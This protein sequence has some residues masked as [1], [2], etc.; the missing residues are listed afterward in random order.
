MVPRVSSRYGGVEVSR[1]YEMGISMRAVP[2]DVVDTLIDAVRDL[3]SWEDWDTNEDPPGLSQLSTYGQGNLSGGRSEEDFAN[4]V[5]D[6][7]W[8]AAGKHIKV[9]VTATYMENL[10]HEHYDYE[11]EEDYD[12]WLKKHSQ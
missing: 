1:Y 12:K 10:P 2:K 5:R 3:W 9:V 11:E 7:I 6:A 8:T 4:D